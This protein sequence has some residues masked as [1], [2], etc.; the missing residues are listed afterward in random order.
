MTV[1]LLPPRDEPSTW[2]PEAA[3]VISPELCLVDP[4]LA[5]RARALLPSYDE[6]EVGYERRPQPASAPAQPYDESRVISHESRVISP[7]L[8]LVDPDL[9]AWARS[10]LPEGPPF[11]PI[12]RNGDK[13]PRAESRPA[14]VHAPEARRNGHASVPRPAVAEVREP[15]LPPLAWGFV[16]DADR[17]LVTPD[18]RRGRRRIRRAAAV[19]GTVA[20][21][22]V[23]LGA[24][25]FAARAIHRTMQNPSA[26]ARDVTRASA[27]PAN[28]NSVQATGSEFPHTSFHPPHLI[29]SAPARRL[30]WARVS[31]ATAYDVRLYRNGRGV[32]AGRTTH[33][34]IK[35]PAHWT[36]GARRIV[37]GP[38]AYIC[39][40]RPVFRVGASSRLGPPVVDVQLTLSAA[41]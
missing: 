2:S 15:P 9:A 39:Y 34:W 5:E 12:A 1:T 19:A 6:A 31:G 30:T 13:A 21:A 18:R 41:H 32:F 24:G 36:S 28:L 23:L 8:A 10:R 33:P 27:Q 17:G 20:A 38:G 37:L 40:V 4:E 25:L 11:F 26:A 22:A 29:A 16:V 3:D 14:A 35:F 7:E